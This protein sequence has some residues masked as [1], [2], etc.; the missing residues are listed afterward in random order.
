MKKSSTFAENMFKQRNSN[1]NLEPMVK[2]SRRDVSAANNEAFKERFQFILYSNDNI[3]CQRYFRIIGYNNDAVGSVELFDA[4]EWCVNAIKEDLWKKSFVYQSIVN[5][6]PTKATGFV[7]DVDNFSDACLVASFGEGTVTLS[8]GRKVEK[9][10]ITH[11]ESQ[12]FDQKTNEWVTKKETSDEIYGESE[13]LKPWDHTFKFEF[14]V[15]ERPVYQRIW[16]GTV[17][18]KHIRNSVDLANTG[19]DLD[20]STVYLNSIDGVLQYIK[21]GRPNLIYQIIKKII[22]VMSGG[23]YEANRFVSD[24]EYS[25]DVHGY[26]NRSNLEGWR[27]ATAEKTR[28]YR[29]WLRREGVEIE[30]RR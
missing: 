15:D 14:R 22:S 24:K 23:H 29:Q 12:V 20:P 9:S 19:S 28:E 13:S 21:I 25:Y 2:E 1:F 27:K 6:N 26:D 30:R 16:D 8:D 10:F 7:N 3:V 4:L 5:N 18:P 11:G 17:Y